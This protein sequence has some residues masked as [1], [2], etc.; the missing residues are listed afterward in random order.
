MGVALVF[1]GT[2]LWVCI[3]QK[4]GETGECIYILCGVGYVRA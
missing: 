1:L 3:L 2:S 4:S